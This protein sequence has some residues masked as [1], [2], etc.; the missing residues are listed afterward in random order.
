MDERPQEAVRAEE[1]REIAKRKLARDIGITVKELDRRALAMKRAKEEL[2]GELGQEVIVTYGI[3]IGRNERL[4]IA[5]VQHAIDEA[6][7][8]IVRAKACLRT[9]QRSTILP[10]Q[11]PTYEPILE[12]L[13][14]AQRLV[15][16]VRPAALC[17]YCKRIA[18]VQME[19][20]PCLG[21]GYIT[22]SAMVHVEDQFTDETK[23]VVRHRGEIVEI[24]KVGK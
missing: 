13:S 15:N 6:W 23:P 14:I 16:G 18:E 2:K 19:C 10:A 11:K 20:V 5:S 24:E 12:Q 7:A 8:N 3:I 1:V 21:T 22:R 17:P 9:L 4:A